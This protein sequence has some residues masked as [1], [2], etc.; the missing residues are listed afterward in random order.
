MQKLTIYDVNQNPLAELD[1]LEDVSYP[2]VYQIA[3]VEKPGS[4]SGSHSKTMKLPGT[5][6]NNQFFGGIYDVNSDYSVFNPNVKTYAVLTVDSEE[7]ITGYMQLKEVLKDDKGEVYYNVVV[8][9]ESVDFW[10]RMRGKYVVNN[11]DSADDIDLSDLDHI[12][13]QANVEAPLD[14][15]WET[16]S[17]YTTTL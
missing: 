8:Y 11:T 3:D 10:S 9:D 7:L 1:L 2:L 16:D 14:R 17:S 12:L 4:K 15:D 5:K 6:T 13:S